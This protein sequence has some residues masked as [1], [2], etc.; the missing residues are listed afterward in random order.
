MAT[1]DVGYDD[2]VVNYDPTTQ[3]G[4]FNWD[5]Y[6]GGVTGTTAPP[7]VEPA[8][9]GGPAGAFDPSLVDAF[10]Q[11]WMA[12]GG[13]TVQDLQAFVAAHPEYGATLTGSKGDKVIFPNQRAFDAVIAAGEG[14][15]RGASWGDITGTSGQGGSGSGANGQPYKF[16]TDDPS[17][18]WRLQ[19]GLDAGQKGAAARGI[20]NTGG[21]LK[22]LTAF[23]QGMAS[24]EYG[25]AF[26]RK[27]TLAELG[28]RAAGGQASAGTSYGQGASQ[29]LGNIGNANSA[30]SI[31]QGNIWGPYLNNL[32]AR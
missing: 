28:V 12:S 23:G 17:Y 4:G 21:T 19:Q 24:T 25:N 29:Q 16:L 32:G 5:Q 7:T 15:G 1:G 14:G 10:G 18:Q 2:G 6:T 31:A 8:P 27:G 30:G 20:L 3:G 22:D 11:A 13:R 26:N 9:G